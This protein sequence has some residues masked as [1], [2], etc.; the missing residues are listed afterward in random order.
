[1]A[2]WDDEAPVDARTNKGTTVVADR[3]G[4]MDMVVDQVEEQQGWQQGRW[5]WRQNH[6]E[7]KR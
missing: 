5:R 1:M 3:G 7:V 6:I 4:K 2:D